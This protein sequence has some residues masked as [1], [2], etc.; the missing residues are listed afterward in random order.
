MENNKLQRRNFLKTT[1]L[2]LGA[3]AFSP[4]ATAS[5]K[6][7]KKPVWKKCALHS[8]THWSDGQSM[9]EVAITEFRN[10]GFDMLVMTEHNAFP[11]DKEAWI[12]ILPK[13][14]GWPPSLTKAEYD[15]TKALYKKSYIEKD[16]AFKK[17][18]KLKTF[19]Q[20]KK[21][22]EIPNKFLLAGGEEITR[23]AYYPDGTHRQC[24]LNVFNVEKT[25]AVDVGA[26]SV[27]DIIKESLSTFNNLKAKSKRPMFMM[28][29]HPFW[30]AWDVLPEDMLKFPELT[31]FEIC[32]CGASYDV[33]EFSSDKFWDVVLANR[34]ER[35]QGVIYATASDDTHYYDPPRVDKKPGGINN[36]WVMARV[37]GDFTVDNTMKA[38]IAG[39]FYPTTGVLLKDV[40][41]DKST[42]TLS[43]EVDAVAGVEYK[44][45]FI[46]TKRGFDHSVKGK[47]FS[48]KNTE[49]VS[50]S[51]RFKRTLPI[52]SDDIG[53]VVKTVKGTKAS[54]KLKY[55]DLY[56][57]AKITSNVPTK[58]TV[59][60]YPKLQCAWTQPLANS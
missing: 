45:E 30:C 32:N 33:S 23:C 18:L 50:I 37:D 39:D 44:I 36:G 31:H 53:K 1:A 38:I 20:L 14:I 15:R 6:S 55:N 17:F 19:D 35:K 26:K 28:L 41:I 27:Q 8:H 52:Y 34:L 2:T 13:S 49:G 12:R 25:F 42:K 40:V 3:T 10:R 22:F 60:C 21:E 9:P 24:H 47:D 5:N 56:V 7:K 16:F 48:P 59:P 58:I 51:Q 29:N 43:V 11:D 57:R 54:Y 46:T 4:I